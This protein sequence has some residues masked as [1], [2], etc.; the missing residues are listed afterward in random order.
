MVGLALQL[1]ARC[2]EEPPW[3]SQRMSLRVLTSTATLWCDSRQLYLVKRTAARINLVGHKGEMD[4]IDM[5]QPTEGFQIRLASSCGQQTAAVV[6]VRTCMGP[7]PPICQYT[8][9]STS[10]FLFHSCGKSLPAFSAMYICNQ[11]LGFHVLAIAHTVRPLSAAAVSQYCALLGPQAVL[12]GSA[13]FG[14]LS[15]QHCPECSAL[16][17]WALSPAQQGTGAWFVLPVVIMILLHTVCKS[18][19]HIYM[20]GVGK[21]HACGGLKNSQVSV[22][23]V[24]CSRT[25]SL[26]GTNSMEHVN[27]E[28]S[29]GFNSE[30]NCLTFGMQAQRRCGA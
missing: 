25:K 2:Q 10:Y 28:Q 17:C 20:I 18:A 8:H 11:S 13:Y 16:P 24:N 26:G 7:S 21:H 6:S 5:M 3:L 15:T 27:P 22:V 1:R 23:M 29:G 4:G 9:C 12:S 30:D 14:L 19:S